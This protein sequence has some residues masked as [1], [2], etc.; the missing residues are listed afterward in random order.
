MSRNLLSSPLTKASSFIFWGYWCSLN[1]CLLPQEFSVKERRERGKEGGGERGWSERLSKG[2]ALARSLNTGD[3]TCG[4]ALFILANILRQFE[5]N[6]HNWRV[7]IKRQIPHFSIKMLKRENPKSTFLGSN[8]GLKPLRMGP[9][10]EVHQQCPQ[11]R[12]C[13]LPAS[14]IA[15][16]VKLCFLPCASQSTRKSKQ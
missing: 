2:N 11:P 1:W 13:R 3:R 7:Y 16:S 10:P 5:L 14:S 4:C 12:A 15:F 8:H 6:F 9:V